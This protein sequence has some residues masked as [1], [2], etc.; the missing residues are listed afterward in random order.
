MLQYKAPLRDIRF[1]LHE[2]LD[3]EKHYAQLPGAR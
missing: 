2:L 3:V 1:V